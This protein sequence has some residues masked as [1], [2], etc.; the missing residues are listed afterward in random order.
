MINSAIED[1]DNKA[2]KTKLSYHARLYKTK[3]VFNV[4]AISKK[5]R[6]GSLD[7][8][9][10]LGIFRHGDGFCNYQ[11][12]VNMIVLKWDKE[13]PVFSR[14]IIHSLQNYAN[15]VLIEEVLKI[16]RTRIRN[17]EKPTLL[18]KGSKGT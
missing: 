16:E 8:K 17:K 1:R 3:L 2:Y 18:K 9:L 15:A 11:E 6:A 14:D 13:N 10:N 4:D 12:V 7:Q 5:W